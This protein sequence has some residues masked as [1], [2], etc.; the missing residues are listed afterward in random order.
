MNQTA[1]QMKIRLSPE[2]KKEIEQSAKKNMRTLNAEIVSR[3]QLT[4][5][6]EKEN[7]PDSSIE[8]IAE[9]VARRI[10]REELNKK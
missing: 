6:L 1:P 5:D 2:L 4:Y 7:S 9:K 10:I 8:A 3:L